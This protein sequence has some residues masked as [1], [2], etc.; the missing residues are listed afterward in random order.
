MLRWDLIILQCKDFAAFIATIQLLQKKPSSFF[1]YL[2][3]VLWIVHSVQGSKCRFCI[4]ICTFFLHL[5]TFHALYT[6]RCEESILPSIFFSPMLLLLRRISSLA[7]ESSLRMYLRPSSLPKATILH[8]PLLHSYSKRRILT[9]LSNQKL[10]PMAMQ[11]VRQA[12]NTAWFPAWPG[13]LSYPA[14]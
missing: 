12:A 8:N 2:Y 7:W 5:Y 14:L 3:L 11:E 10:S 6:F 4:I 1:H 13:C 9:K